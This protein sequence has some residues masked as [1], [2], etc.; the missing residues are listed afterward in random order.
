M[1]AIP[2]RMET[3]EKSLSSPLQRPMHNPSTAPASERGPA[4]SLASYLRSCL[5][6]LSGQP[7]LIGAAWAMP[8]RVPAQGRGRETELC[9]ILLQGEVPKAEGVLLHQVLSGTRAGRTPSVAPR[10][11]PPR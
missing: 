4:P 10:Q 2:P 5:L 11:L 8:R 9:I 6:L 3:F 1:T 7:G